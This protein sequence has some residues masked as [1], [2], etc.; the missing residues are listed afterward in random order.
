MGLLLIKPAELLLFY[1]GADKGSS[2]VSFSDAWQGGAD[3]RARQSHKD[4]GHD[5][6]SDMR[7]G[8]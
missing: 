3:S 2:V 1:T 7:L 8:P 6:E 5:H 4:T